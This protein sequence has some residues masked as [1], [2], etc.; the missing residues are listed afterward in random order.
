VLAPAFIVYAVTYWLFQRGLSEATQRANL[1]AA[2]RLDLAQASTL[3]VERILSRTE[4]DQLQKDIVAL[5]L[6]TFKGINS[7]SL[8]LID[9]DRRN[10]KRAA[11]TLES[12]P[13][14][15]TI[16]VG[17]LHAIGRVAI[18]GQVLVV[19]N[20][21]EE[22][23]YRR[24][25]LPPGIESQLLLPLKVAADTIGILEL[26]S[27]LINSFERADIEAL[28]RMA[29]QIAVGIDN[30]RLFA[31]AQNSLNENKRLY[32][33]TRANLREIERLN[34]QLTGQSW[35]EYLRAR[36]SAISHTFDF[37]SANFDEYAEWTPSLEEAVQRKH[38]VVHNTDQ[39]QTVSF[40]IAVRGQVIGAMEFELDHEQ[41]VEPGRLDA[42][43]EAINRMALSAEN[44]R[45]FDEAQRIAQREAMVNEISER[46]Q[47]TTSVEV[48]VG[49]AAQG[50]ASVLRTSRVAIRIGTPPS[51]EPI[52]GNAV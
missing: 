25:A 8:W 11:S 49:A 38:I 43:G 37:G 46:M 15:E 12:A 42:I 33:Q 44:I 47:G 39:G 22:T 31:A 6:Q 1:A 21:P 3:L 50:L 4:Q 10:V 32:E 28:G 40:P 45:L 35:S 36:P 16:G 2:R 27:S 5:L 7:V 24:N 13:I 29:D 52:R 51:S 19:R 17:T 48:T 20:V 41:V 30:A 18:A 23:A 14:G 9:S 26:Q 34:Q